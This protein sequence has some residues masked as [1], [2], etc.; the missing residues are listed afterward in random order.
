MSSMSMATQVADLNCA[1]EALEFRNAA[2]LYGKMS[3]LFGI[4]DTLITL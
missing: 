1:V 2:R 4:D 3:I